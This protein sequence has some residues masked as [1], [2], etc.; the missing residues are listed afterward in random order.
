MSAAPRSRER[1]LLR[2]QLMLPILQIEVAIINP[3]SL[4]RFTWYQLACIGL[5]SL[6]ELFYCCFP[7]GLKAAER[8]LRFPPAATIF[9]VRELA[10]HIENVSVRRIGSSRLLN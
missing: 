6:R 7:V 9:E 4:S 8:S 1:S 3:H 5:A 10:S 2:I